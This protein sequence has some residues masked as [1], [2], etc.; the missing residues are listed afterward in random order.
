MAQPVPLDLLVVKVCKATPGQL[1]LRVLPELQGRQV[2]LV[3]LRFLSMARPL[4]TMMATS[5]L[6]YQIR[7]RRCTFTTAAMEMC[8]TCYCKCQKVTPPFQILLLQALTT[9]VSAHQNQL[10]PCTSLP[11]A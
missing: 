8:T 9:W 11:A 4:I 7:R 5:D 10:R 2:P 3:H 1:A 6:A